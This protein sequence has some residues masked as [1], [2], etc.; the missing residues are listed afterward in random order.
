VLVIDK[1]RAMPAVVA[2]RRRSR[3]IRAAILT[4]RR[5]RILSFWCAFVAAIPIKETLL[6]VPTL[7]CMVFLAQ[8]AP[9]PSQRA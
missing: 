4:F 6:V 3:P 7:A 1:P 9:V 5:H 8:Q 2:S